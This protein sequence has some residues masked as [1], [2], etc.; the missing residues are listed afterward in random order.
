MSKTMMKAACLLAAALLFLAGAAQAETAALPEGD[1]T[2]LPQLDR[3]SIGVQTGTNFDA[4]IPGILPKAK[5]EYFNDKADLAAALT[6]GKI[7]GFVMDE[8]V[9]QYLMK[10]NGDVTYIPEYLDSYRFAFVFPRSEQGEALRNQFNEFLAGLQEAGRLDALKDKW[11]AEDEAEK[12]MP[13]YAS[14]P[15]DKSSAPPSP[16]P[17]RWIRGSSC[18]TSRQARWTPQW[19]VKYRPSSASWQNPARPS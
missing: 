15:A 2:A 6:S 3:K 13:D 17:L 12:S 19:W 10:E 5:I 16:A 1:Y 4:M 9:V 18:R 7:E 8:P 11:F 14:F